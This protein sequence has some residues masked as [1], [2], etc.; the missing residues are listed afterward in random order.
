MIIV[1]HI[2]AQRVLPP[3]NDNFADATVISGT[4]YSDSVDVTAATTEAEEP[5]NNCFYSVQD[6][7]WYKFVAPSN[8]SV[9]VSLSGT[10]W[11]ETPLNV[12]RADG[13]GFAGLSPS[14]ECSAQNGFNVNVEAGKTY[15]SKP[16]HLGG[17][18]VR[19]IST[20]RLHQHPPTTILQTQP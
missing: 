15:Y 1:S 6:T 5:L 4:S 8:G 14:L 18:V 2:V 19:W 9:Y 16:A 7:V 17:T 11:D 13:E 12:Y 3:V 10:W 20:C